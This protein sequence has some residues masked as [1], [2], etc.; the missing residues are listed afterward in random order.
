MSYIGSMIFKKSKTGY[1]I[2]W[3]RI[4]ISNVSKMIYDGVDFLEVYI[5]YFDYSWA[6]KITVKAV[7]EN[8]LGAVQPVVMTEEFSKEFLEFFGI[9]ILDYTAVAADPERLLVN[10][11]KVTSDAQRWSKKMN[12]FLNSQQSHS[13]YTTPKN[14]SKVYQ[15]AHIHGDVYSSD[16]DARIKELE[17]EIK[18]LKEEIEM[19]KAVNQEC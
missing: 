10:L 19:L 2:D 8:K 11:V 15:Q 17:E 9:N 7:P 5:E 13:T 18:D 6:V 3:E 14:F 4:S 1:I 16:K 12:N